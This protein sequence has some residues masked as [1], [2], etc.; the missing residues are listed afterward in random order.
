[1]DLPIEPRNAIGLEL[2]ETAALINCFFIL[3]LFW[4]V[5]NHI[6]KIKIF[7][8]DSLISVV[9]SLSA[10]EA[11]LWEY[12]IAQNQSCIAKNKAKSQNTLLDNH[13]LYVCNL[14]AYFFGHRLLRRRFQDRYKSKVARFLSLCFSLYPL[15]PPFHRDPRASIFTKSL[16]HPPSIIFHVSRPRSVS[17]APRIKGI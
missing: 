5:V 7:A 14:S 3:G 10:E 12:N 11:L 16:A 4:P 2:F 13:L 6:I 15:L 17:Y 9:W 1:M 8:C